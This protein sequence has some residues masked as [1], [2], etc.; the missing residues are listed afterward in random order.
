M[1]ASDLGAPT[2]PGSEPSLLQKNGGSGVDPP[3]QDSP[4]HQ[5]APLLQGADGSQDAAHPTNK[6]KKVFLNPLYFMC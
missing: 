2:S 6:G 5:D 4:P 3:R 1:S